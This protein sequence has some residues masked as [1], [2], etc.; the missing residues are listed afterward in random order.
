MDRIG[1]AT[2]IFYMVFNLIALVVGKHIV[3][4]TVRNAVYL[5]THTLLVYFTFV[6]TMGRSLEEIDEAFGD[7]N[8]AAMGMG[9]VKD[10][11]AVM[12]AAEYSAQNEKTEKDNDSKA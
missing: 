12:H 5:D 11:A 4:K 3:R 9:D 10:P 7:V 2:Y 6:E 8:H 1:W